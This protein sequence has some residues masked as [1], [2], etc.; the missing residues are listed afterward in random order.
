LGRLA[1]KQAP[2]LSRRVLIFEQN[3]QTFEQEF[4]NSQGIFE[5]ENRQQPVIYGKNMF[6]GCW[7]GFCYLLRQSERATHP[8][9]QAKIK[10]LLVS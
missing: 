9:M 6:L 10:F 3:V 5:R 2:E 8:P 1:P 7:P 4:L